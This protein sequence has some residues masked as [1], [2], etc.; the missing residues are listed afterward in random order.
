MDDLLQ[1]VVVVRC[2]EMRMVYA[3]NFMV[4]DAA[5]MRAEGVDIPADAFDGDGGFHMVGDV[6]EVVALLSCP[7]KAFG[8]EEARDPDRGVRMLV[9]R[10]EDGEVRHRWPKLTGI[11]QGRIGPG[12]FDEINPLLNACTAFLHVNAEG[13]KLVAQEAASDTEIE[14]PLR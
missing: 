13:I 1:Q 11:L 12:T 6:E 10:G 4:F 8:R 14:S 3:A 7:R 5:A 9:D 2:Q